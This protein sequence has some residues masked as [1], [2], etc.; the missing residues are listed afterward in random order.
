MWGEVLGGF[1]TI[2]LW[3]AHLIPEQKITAGWAIII[4]LS[5]I[6]I[7]WSMSNIGWSTLISDI[8]RDEDRSRIMGKLEGL[9]GVGRILDTNGL[10]WVSK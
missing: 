10:D 8:Y 4:G 9:G 2:L 3:Y 1:G 5:I 6:E 7:F